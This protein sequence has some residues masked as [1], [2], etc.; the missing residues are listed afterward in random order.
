MKS[1]TWGNS[2]RLRRRR[3][4]TSAQGSALG[5][6]DKYK[7]ENSVRVR[8]DAYNTP[9]RLLRPTWLF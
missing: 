3:S 6:T 4:L 1:Q 7:N 2:S 5:K 9:H 8:K